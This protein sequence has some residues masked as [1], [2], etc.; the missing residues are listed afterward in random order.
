MFV[1]LQI[2]ENDQNFN[3]TASILS[4]LYFTVRPIITAPRFPN[5]VDNTASTHNLIHFPFS[6]NILPKIFGT[7]L[8]TGILSR[9]SR[10]AQHSTPHKGQQIHNSRRPLRGVT[11][12]LIYARTSAV[13]VAQAPPP[14]RPPPGG[15][16]GSELAWLWAAALPGLLPPPPHSTPDFPLHPINYLWLQMELQ[17]LCGHVWIQITV[18]DRQLVVCIAVS[19]RLWLSSNIKMVLS[20]EIIIIICCCLCCCCSFE[21]F[22]HSQTNWCVCVCARASA[23]TCLLACVP[24]FASNCRLY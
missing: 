1:V 3:C 13:T 14:P 20:C 19:V 22:I 18:R 12:S 16:A 7:S 23:H 10:H 2:R 9:I 5:V 15:R 24:A 21:L 8:G 4:S 11:M 6:P 17:K